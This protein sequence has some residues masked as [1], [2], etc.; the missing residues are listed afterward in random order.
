MRE[1]ESIAMTGHQN[2]AIIDER[3]LRRI[4]EEVL[5][6]EAEISERGREYLVN[7]MREMLMCGLQHID[8]EWRADYWLDR[9][10][11]EILG[12]RR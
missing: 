11:D 12:E 4:L 10:Y 1:P 6:G 8:G 9:V 2:P 7:L 5:P 3:I